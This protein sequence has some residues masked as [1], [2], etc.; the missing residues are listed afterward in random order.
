MNEDCFVHSPH[1]SL[2]FLYLKRNFFILQHW[3]NF[4]FSEKLLLLWQYL[5]KYG[6][7]GK[8]SMV[9]WEKRSESGIPCASFMYLAPLDASL[10]GLVLY[11]PSRCALSSYPSTQ[12]TPSLHS[13]TPYHTN[14]FMVPKSLSCAYFLWFSSI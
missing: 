13:S 9:M 10:R 11:P 2:Y 14:P 1:K 8:E 12:H 3:S 7:G 6:M 4:Y 5:L